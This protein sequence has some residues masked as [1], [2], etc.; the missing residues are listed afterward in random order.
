[1][2]TLGI[3]VILLAALSCNAQVYYKSGTFKVENATQSTTY[4]GIQGAPIVST[5]HF[6][7]I[8]KKC[9]RISFDSFWA[10]G[11]ADKVM[12]SY[13]NGDAWDGKPLKGD[14]L[15]VSLEYNR[16]TA[17]DMVFPDGVGVLPQGSKQEEPPVKHKGKALFR[18]F[19]DG[20]SQ[21]FSIEKIAKG[22]DIYAP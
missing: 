1:M 14:T 7:L 22:N 8:L 9:T 21:Y 16:S 5:M 11:F 17:Q 3:L 18:Y 15:L 10:D 6:T 19:L 2:R 4:P 20:K 12:I 13:K